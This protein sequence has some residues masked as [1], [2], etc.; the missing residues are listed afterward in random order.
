MTPFPLERSYDHIIAGAGC[1]GLSLAVRMALSGR[2]SDQRILLLDRSDKSVND[3]TWCFWE[4]GKG[5]FEPIVHRSWS[6]AWFHDGDHSRLLNL[7]PYRYKMIRGIDFYRHA[8][9]IL[10]EHPYITIEQAEIR[11]VESGPLKATVHTVDDAISAPWVYSSLMPVRQNSGGRYHDLLQHFKGR[12]IRTDRPCFN[13]AEATLMDFRPSQEHGTTFVYVMPFSET[14]ALVEYTL[15][16]PALL[17]QAEYDDGLQRYVKDVLGIADHEVMEEEFGVI[18]MSDRP[19][20]AVEGRL[21]HI[22]TAG[23]QTKASTGY[24]FQFIQKQADAIVKALVAAGDPSKGMPA[25]MTRFHW[26]DSVLLN[27][28]ANGRLE[29]H[30]VFR[31]LFQRN[32]TSSILRFLDNESSFLQELRLL[33]SLPMWPFMKAGVKELGKYIN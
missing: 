5:F 8:F 18:P 32:D 33:N 7:S 2:F 21:L 13:P 14:E 3:R 16:S 23:G 17:E 1:A 15:F 9:A 4:E 28:L 22:G 26:Y 31:M 24:T 6:H 12:V 19:F 30:E 27:V 25:G 11:S 20:P 10:K 29:G